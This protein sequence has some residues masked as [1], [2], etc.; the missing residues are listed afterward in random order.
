MHS[1]IRLWIQEVQA[2]PGIPANR[3]VQPLPGCVRFRILQT[4][5]KRLFLRLRQPGPRSK[6]NRSRYSHSE[7]AFVRSGQ[8]DIWRKSPHATRFGFRERNLFGGIGRG[9]RRYGCN[10]VQ[11]VNP[12]VKDCR[13]FDTPIK[14][15]KPPVSHWTCLAESTNKQDSIQRSGCFICTSRLEGLWLVDCDRP[16]KPPPPGSGARKHVRQHSRSW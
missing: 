13:E 8:M 12:C 5:G 14:R 15:T 6:H 4:F 1:W 9:R 2:N 3:W 7:R 16:G 11:H 10:P